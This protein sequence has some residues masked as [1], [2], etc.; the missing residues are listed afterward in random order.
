MIITILIIFT[1]VIGLVLAAFYAYD[2]HIDIPNPL[3]RVQ[4]PRQFSK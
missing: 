3:G 2:R 1:V 4:R